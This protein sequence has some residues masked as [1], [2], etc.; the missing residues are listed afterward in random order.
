MT[1]MTFESSS[2]SP[3]RAAVRRSAAP[4]RHPVTTPEAPPASAA[5]RP[6]GLVFGKRNKAGLGALFG[7]TLVLHGAVI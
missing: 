5:V 6:A 7:L 1:T 3:R 2:F 4:V